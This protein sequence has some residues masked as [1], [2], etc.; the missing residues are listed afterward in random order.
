[1]DTRQLIQAV[2]AAVLGTLLGGGGVWQHKAD[3]VE[4]VGSG[5]EQI[6]EANT[7][8]MQV[9]LEELIECRTRKEESNAP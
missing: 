5:V 4:T 3:Q 8:Q 9:V 1:M 7:R 6:I 2:V